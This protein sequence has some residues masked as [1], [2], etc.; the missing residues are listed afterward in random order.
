M[1]RSLFAKNDCI[2]SAS[3]AAVSARRGPLLHDRQHLPPVLRTPAFH[4]QR[5]KH[6]IISMDD[7]LAVALATLLGGTEARAQLEVEIDFDGSVQPAIVDNGAGDLNATPTS[8]TSTSPTG[9][10]RSFGAR[11]VSARVGPGRRAPRFTAITPDANGVL[12]NDG[13]ADATSR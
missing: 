10:T 3:G 4:R 1:R 7:V 5:G 2:D 9:S 8:S 6:E 13:A 11:A 12:R